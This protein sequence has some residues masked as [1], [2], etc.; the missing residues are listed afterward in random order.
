M[1]QINELKLEL[2]NKENFSSS[3]L[4]EFNKK[5]NDL[6]DH[7]NKLTEQLI[8]L[9]NKFQV[10]NQLNQE[11]NLKL[12]ELNKENETIKTENEKLQENVKIFLEKFFHQLFLRVVLPYICL[13]NF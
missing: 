4:E 11:K 6:S 1:N 13:D 10:Q 8:S 9:Q 3:T 2:Q 12:Q 7:N 5:L